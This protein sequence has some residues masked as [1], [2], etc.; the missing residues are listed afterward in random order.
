MTLD[1]NAWLQ[2]I[3]IAAILVGGLYALHRVDSRMASTIAV[4]QNEIKH[5]WHEMN[6]IK[7]VLER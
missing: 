5:L 7:K 4:L 1:A 6:E 3:Q 2:I